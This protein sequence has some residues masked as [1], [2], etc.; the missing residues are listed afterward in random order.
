M[1]RRQARGDLSEEEWPTGPGPVDALAFDSRASRLAVL[2]LDRDYTLQVRRLP[3]GAVLWAASNIVELAGFLGADS[4]AATVRNPLDPQGSRALAM[5]RQEGIAVRLEGQFLPAGIVAGGEVIAAEGTAGWRFGSWAPGESHW[6]EWTPWTD[7]PGE[8]LHRLTARVSA[9]GRRWMLCAGVGD[10]SYTSILAVAGGNSKSRVLA[11]F[12]GRTVEEG[13]AAL[14]SDGS[15]AAVALAQ[16][17]AVKVY[18]IDSGEIQA[19]HTHAGVRTLAFSP[20]SVG[21]PRPVTTKP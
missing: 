3:G 1:L 5:V 20:N 8:P 19:S 6:K 7:L 10:E 12:W 14:S 11:Q 4:V 17:G 16:D 15:R 9:E 18:D 21:S 13:A 2:Y